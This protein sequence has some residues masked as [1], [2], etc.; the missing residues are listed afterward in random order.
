MK[1]YWIVNPE[2][3]ETEGYSLKDGHYQSTGSGK[4]GIIQSELLGREFRF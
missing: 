2:T 4:P 1:E 3:M